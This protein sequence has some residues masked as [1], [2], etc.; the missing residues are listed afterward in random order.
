MKS[1]RRTAPLPPPEAREFLDALAAMLADAVPRDEAEAAKKRAAPSLKS[2]RPK[3]E[4]GHR[5]QF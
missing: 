4:N 1:R 2:E 5:H 3:A